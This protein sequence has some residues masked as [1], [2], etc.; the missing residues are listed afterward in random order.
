MATLNP[1]LSGI[2]AYVDESREEL[3]TKTILGAKSIAMFDLMAGVKGATAIHYLNSDLE[4]DDATDCGFNPKGNDI[5][6][7]RIVKPIYL[8]VNKEFCSKN[9]LDSYIAYKLKTAAGQD[10]LPYEADFLNQVSEQIQNKLEK[11]V[12][13]GDSANPNTFDGIIKQAKADGAKV[14]SKAAGTS[15]YSCVKEGYLSVPEE[16]V[17]QGD[18]T[19]FM[20]DGLFRNLVQELVALNYFHITATDTPMQITLPGTNVRIVAVHGLNGGNATHDF[21]VLMRSKN[22][23]YATDMM[24]DSETFDWWYSKDTQTF[25]LDVEWFSGIALKFPDEVT[26]IEL[27]K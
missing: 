1:Q 5:I 11:M 13:L 9:L 27:A 12:W 2:T 16:V 8:K 19:I 18:F 6:S 26:I 3:L 20:S 10:V 14:I 24:S 23:V 25:R 21:I 22:A 4:F 17:S 15:I 7:Q